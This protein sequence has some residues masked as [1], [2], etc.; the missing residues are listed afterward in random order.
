MRLRKSS[1]SGRQLQSTDAL[2][3]IAGP[4]F[5]ESVGKIMFSDSLERCL[6]YWRVHDA[7]QSTPWESFHPRLQSDA[8]LCRRWKQKII[9]MLGGGTEFWIEIRNVRTIRKQTASYVGIRHITPGA[10][11]FS[12]ELRVVD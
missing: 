12:E 3:L 2:Y 11:R 9:V 4:L 8:F 5:K 6:A 7:E 1:G 10:I